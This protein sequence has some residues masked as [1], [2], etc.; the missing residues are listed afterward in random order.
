MQ[1]SIFWVA[2]KSVPTRQLLTFADDS[3]PRWITCAQMVDYDTV[4]CGDKF[5][6]V[7]INRIPNH[8]SLSVDDDP[9]GAGILHDKPFLGG[10][11]NKT[12]LLAHFNAGGI[13]TS[14]V[15][16]LNCPLPLESLLIHICFD[17]RMTKIPLV[18][19]GRE[20]LVYTK[21]DGSIGALIP[22]TTKDDI[23]FMTTLEMVSIFC[24]EDE[25]HIISLPLANVDSLPLTAYAINRKRLHSRTRS[26][27]LQRLLRSSQSSSRWRFGRSVRGLTLFETA[28]YLE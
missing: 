8:V 28:E 20:V 13:L 9:T 19:G 27:F 10:A 18:A 4:A 14:W 26:A 3:Q 23:E 17:C 24:L 7:F 15:Y 2:Y 5:G 1:E 16:R 6:N 21:L 12:D 11:S 25:V 22:F